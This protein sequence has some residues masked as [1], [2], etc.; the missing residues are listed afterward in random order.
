MPDPK[1]SAYFDREADGYDDRFTSHPIGRRY[2]QTVWRA[3]EAL[4]NASRRLLD[5]GAVTALEPSPGMLDVARAQ[6]TA[7]TVE[8]VHADLLGWEPQGRRWPVVLSNFGA[9]NCIGSADRR[10]PRQSCRTWRI[11]R[12]RRHGAVLSVGDGVFCAARR[13]PGVSALAHPARR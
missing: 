1:L 7:H 5:I 2:R 3:V 12:R 4:P 6:T 10:T 8:T 9:L 11:P 13:C